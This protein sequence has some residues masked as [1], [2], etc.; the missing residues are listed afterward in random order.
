MTGNRRSLDVQT[1][2]VDVLHRQVPGIERYQTSGR[3]DT[4]LVSSH[5]HGTCGVEDAF[6]LKA[7][8]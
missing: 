2:V 3:I 6:L 5:K 7:T 1:F 4:P 8:S